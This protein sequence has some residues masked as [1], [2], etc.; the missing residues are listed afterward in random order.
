MG[1]RVILGLS[2]CLLGWFWISWP[3]RV[4]QDFV[5][6]VEGGEADKWMPTIVPPAYVPQENETWDVE[7]LVSHERTMR[8][9]LEARQTFSLEV[10]SSG[11]TLPVSFEVRRGKIFNLEAD[12]VNAL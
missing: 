2:F 7:K 4:A 5:V 10:E 8:D 11:R 9:Y 1:I 12:F 6:S 3:L